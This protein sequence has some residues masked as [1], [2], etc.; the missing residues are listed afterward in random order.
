MNRHGQ[1]VSTVDSLRRVKGDQSLY[2]SQKAWALS[3][4]GRSAEA[5]EELER[6]RMAGLELYEEVAVAY[7]RQLL[8]EEPTGRHTVWLRIG[9]QWHRTQKQP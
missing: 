7:L 6:N 4:S 5:L 2:V 3:R 9:R 8:E 1:V